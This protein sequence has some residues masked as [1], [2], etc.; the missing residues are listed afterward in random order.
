V[1][2]MPKRR[3]LITGATGQDGTYLA[4]FLISK[5]YEIIGLDRPG[6]TPRSALAR[7]TEMDIRDSGRLA[8]YVKE[9]RPDECYHLAAFHQ[10]SSAVEGERK[11]EDERASFETNLLS[12]HAI[13]NA[14]RTARADCRVFLAGSC[15]MFGD[16]SETPQTEATPLS[17]VNTYGVTKTAASHMGRLY[18]EREGMFVC[19]GI[20]YNHESP[21]RGPHFVTTKIARAA[22]EA[23]RGAADR[24][25][26]GNLDAQVDWGFAGDYVRAMHLVLQAEHPEDFI[27]ASGELHRVRDFAEIAFRRAGLDWTKYVSEDA[28]A[29]RPVSHSVYRGDASAIRNKLGWRPETPFSDLVRMMVDHYLDSEGVS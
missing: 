9:I 13:L 29:Y 8:D 24:L 16:A 17:P 25:V 23:S 14:L 11:G 26:L 15:H 7:F 22:A 2:L 19:T 21:L 1:S 3:A 4:D 6:S 27:I 20:L 18:R 12:V 5:D 10:S 28:S